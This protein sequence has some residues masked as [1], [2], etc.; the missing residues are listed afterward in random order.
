MSP[1]SGWLGLSV[2]RL[3]NDD[4]AMPFSLAPQPGDDEHE[5]A[6][7]GA[8]VNYDLTR[9]PNCGVNLYE[10][11]DEEGGDDDATGPS[12][13]ALAREGLLAQLGKF[14]KGLW[15]APHPAEGLFGAS[16]EQMI[17]YNDLLLKVGGDHAT[18]RRLIEF[19]GKRLPKATRTVW[20]QNAIRRWERDNQ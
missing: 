11:D 5:C 16:R 10:P 1:S 13:S 17:L 18:V 7:C 15:A 3:G 8:L 9:C 4:L 2:F 6:R 20:L 12:S 14:L 19:E